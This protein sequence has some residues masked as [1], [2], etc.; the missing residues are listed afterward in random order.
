MGPGATSDNERQPSPVSDRLAGLI[1]SLARVRERVAEAARRAGRPVEE[2]RLIGITKGV[3][4]EI[5]GAAARA[6]LGEFGENYVQEL[7]SKRTM[8]PAATW[9]FVGRLQRNKIHH[10]VEAADVVQTLEP[11]PAGERLARLAAE[12]GPV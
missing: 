3:P 6:G 1:G 10:V 11:G 9:H 5:V 12:R 7:R 8:A 4:A 2:V